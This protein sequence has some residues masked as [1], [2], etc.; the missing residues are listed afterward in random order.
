MD[1][2]KALLESVMLRD[3]E[4]VEK[5]LAAGADPMVRDERG[6][7][8]LHWAAAKHAYQLIPVLVRAGAEVDATDV[9]GL[10]PLMKACQCGHLDCV[11]GFLAHGADVHRAS[12]NGH[13]ALHWLA[14]EE[15]LDVV[16]ALVAH[17]ADPFAQ[18]AGGKTLL[19]LILNEPRLARN[20]KG[21][22]IVLYLC[23]V[24]GIDPDDA[25]HGKTFADHYAG[26]PGVSLLRPAASPSFAM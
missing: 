11:R 13:R 12:K 1:L 5:A 6:L 9:H 19:E 16:R 3:Q 7:T 15:N 26:V 21:A 18:G 4:G 20:V 10:T 14:G 23:E 17:G 2:N 8:P 22:A 25:F 24:M